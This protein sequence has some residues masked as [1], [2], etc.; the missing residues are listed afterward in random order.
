[1]D[2][3][4]GVPSLEAGIWRSCVKMPAQS[5][6]VY[7]ALDKFRM[8]KEGGRGLIDGGWMT[9]VTLGAHVRGPLSRKL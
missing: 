2:K 6:D 7:K 5:E 9:Q 4:L 8:W 1:M 3:A